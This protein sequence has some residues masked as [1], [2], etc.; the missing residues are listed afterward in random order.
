MTSSETNSLIP[1]AIFDTNICLD[2]FVFHDP[3]S[4]L[5][6]EHIKAGKLYA[7]TRNDCREEWLRVLDYP[8]L[9]IE[10]SAKKQAIEDFDRFIHVIEPEKKDKHLL[11]VCTDRDDQKF[12][13][14][15]YDAG[16]QFLFSKDKA[17]LKLAKRNIKRGL[18]QILTPASWLANNSK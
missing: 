8:Q 16:A 13:E 12:L 3:V 11:P 17:V 5:V 18:F 6:L 10:E 2:F 9:S 14:I 15:A 7:V 4:C 1:T